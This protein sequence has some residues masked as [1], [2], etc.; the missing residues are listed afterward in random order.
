MAKRT[1]ASK[2]TEIFGTNVRLERTRSKQ[3]LEDLAEAA[4]TTASYLSQVERAL[5]SPSLD[6]VF[7]IAKAL[8]VT[9]I[10]LMDETLGRR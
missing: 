6:A 9:P 3:T 4:G 1:A 10:A 7:R 5:V 8:R 2:L